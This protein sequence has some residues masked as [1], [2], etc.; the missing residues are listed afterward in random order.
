MIH[1]AAGGV[2]STQ[3]V[4]F[5]VGVGEDVCVT[6]A[7]LCQCS[8]PVWFHVITVPRN[9]TFCIVFVND[10][11]ENDCLHLWQSH[12]KL[13]A[14]SL[15]KHVRRT[16]LVLKSLFLWHYIPPVRSNSNVVLLREHC[17]TAELR[18]AAFDVQ[19]FEQ[20]RALLPAHWLHTDQGYVPHTTT[21]QK[22]Q[23]ITSSF[24]KQVVIWQLHI[25]LVLFCLPELLV[26]DSFIHFV[27]CKRSQVTSIGFQFIYLES[28]Y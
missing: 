24:N 19:Q 4:F 3:M 1:L 16:I 6:T 12:H 25:T 18:L 10:T 2:G 15:I 22:T 5:E 14:L 21:R 17:A 11:N 26:D 7:S 9:R 23:S 20:H 27:W 8:L 28:V 13:K